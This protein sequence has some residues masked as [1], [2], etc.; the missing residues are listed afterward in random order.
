MENFMTEQNKDLSNKT[1][2]DWA[3]ENEHTEIVKLLETH[4]SFN[5]I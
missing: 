3:K 2:L 5:K 1:A 4:A